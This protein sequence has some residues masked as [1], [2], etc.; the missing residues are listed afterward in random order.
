M[1]FEKD[2]IYHVYNRGNNHQKIFFKHDNYIYFLNKIRKEL[3]PYCDFLAY[4][5]MP[6]HFH[7][8]FHAGKAFPS[9]DLKSSDGL[10]P[11]EK[12]QDDKNLSKQISNGIAIILRSYAQAINKQENRTGSLFQQK[13]KAK[14]LSNINQS[15]VLTKNYSIQRHFNNY[16]FLCFQYIHQNPINANLV[17]K[18]EDWHYS[19]F[20]DYS[21]MRNGT[22]CNKELAE[23][24][25][26]LDKENFYTQSYM[27]IDERNLKLIW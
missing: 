19:S 25:V 8:L 4:C 21:G 26:N 24:I 27:T 5:L 16:A 1:Q 9:D 22:L 12:Y 10:K 13:T 11:T 20:R 15:N 17:N 2:N 23:E 7:F 3:I 18:L 14:N 6:N